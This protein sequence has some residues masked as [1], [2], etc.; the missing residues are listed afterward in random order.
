MTYDGHELRFVAI[1]V[2]RPPI[3]HDASASWELGGYVGREADA[4]VQPGLAAPFA[5]A[6]T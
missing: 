4:T 6:L 3:F 1:V 5:A 2:S